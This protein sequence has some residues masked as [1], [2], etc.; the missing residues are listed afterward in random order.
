[1]WN[2]T[3]QDCTASLPVVQWRCSAP[4]SLPTS[5]QPQHNV[6]LTSW[7]CADGQCT[8]RAQ[9]GRAAHGRL[10]PNFP[11]QIHSS[12][13]MVRDVASEEWSSP[14][15][16]PKRNT[17]SRREQFPYILHSQIGTTFYY[18]SQLQGEADLCAFRYLFLGNLPVH[19]RS[20]VAMPICLRPCKFLS[21]GLIAQLSACFHT[22]QHILPSPWNLVVC[23]S[24]CY[25]MLDTWMWRRCLLC[26]FA[27]FSLKSLVPQAMQPWVW[28]KKGKLPAWEDEHCYR[29]TPLSSPSGLC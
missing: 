3:S 28:G 16:E 6:K 8:K 26:G 2:G 25:L 13:G 20:H 9:R 10:E 12:H 27:F 22:S 24:W 29:H 15:S 1:M 17:E 18:P 21:E 7:R 4:M 11:H 23:K 14:F 19:M 5:W